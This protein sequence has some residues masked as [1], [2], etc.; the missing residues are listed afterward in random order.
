MLPG[1]VGGI[2]KVSIMPVTHPQLSHSFIPLKPSHGTRYHFAETLMLP[3]HCIRQ[4][5]QS[6]QEG[7]ILGSGP[8]VKFC[9]A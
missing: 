6:L 4:D 3:Q 5:P 7:E 8:A 9:T 1:S 2:V